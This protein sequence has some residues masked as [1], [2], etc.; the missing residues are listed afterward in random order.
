MSLYEYQESQEI[1]SKNYGFYSLIMAAIRKADAS[2]LNMLCLAFP[3]TYSE[4]KARY[5][6]PG[7][8]LES[9]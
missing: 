8:K 5:N 9:D 7:G 3:E 4:L 2:N 1:E 6:S